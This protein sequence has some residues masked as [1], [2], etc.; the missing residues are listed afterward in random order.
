MKF[1]ILVKISCLLFFLCISG[2]KEEL[3]KRNKAFLEFDQYYPTPSQDWPRTSRRPTAIGHMTESGD[4]N[5]GK[6]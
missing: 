2:I 1:H 4:L 3:L 6:S 5:S